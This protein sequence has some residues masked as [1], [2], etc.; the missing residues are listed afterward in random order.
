MLVSASNKILV[1]KLQVQEINDLNADY[2]NK[3][4]ILQKATRIENDQN[5]KIWLKLKHKLILI[6]N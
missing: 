5:F 4:P 2:F 3:I 1:I 6:S